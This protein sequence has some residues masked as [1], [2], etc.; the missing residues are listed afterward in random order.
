MSAALQPYRTVN[1]SD[2]GESLPMGDCPR[3]LFL[4]HDELSGMAD[5]SDF[6]DGIVHE[7]TQVHGDRVDLTVDTVAALDGR[8]R[9]D[10]GGDEH[11]PARATLLDPTRRDSDD[12]YGWWELPAGTYLLEYNEALREG[13]F[14][15]QPHPRLLVLGATHPTMWVSELSRVPLQVPDEGA[16]IKE[17]ARVSTLV[18]RG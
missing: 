17:N 14:M 10:F 12:D 13:P 2:I 8:G 3:T 7:P 16:A 11:A 4:S 15:L 6:I 1:A 5:P 9:I 18:D